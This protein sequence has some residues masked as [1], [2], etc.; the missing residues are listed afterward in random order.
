M[1]GHIVTSRPLKVACAPVATA[2]PALR[3]SRPHASYTLNSACVAL[4]VG[5]SSWAF[6]RASAGEFL[7]GMY[8]AHTCSKHHTARVMARQRT[9]WVRAAHSGRVRA[10]RAQHLFDGGEADRRSRGQRLGV[11]LHHAL[12]A[13]R[14]FKG[15]AGRV[16]ELRVDK[17]RD[18]AARLVEL[19]DVGV[20]LE[21]ELVDVSRER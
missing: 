9:A 3:S 15:G 10:V 20:E 4:C 6:P 19:R 1:Q 14:L 2:A 11:V 5:A 17:L 18:D 7:T 21:Y 12:E 16:L 13:R 8:V